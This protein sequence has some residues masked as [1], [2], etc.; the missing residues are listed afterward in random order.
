M[1]TRIILH[2]GNAHKRTDKNDKFFN[3]VISG[4]SSGETIRVL[5]I[6]FARPEHRW[7][8]SYDEDQYMFRR[9]ADDRGVEI[10]TLLATYDID[11]LTEKIAESDVI[12]INGGMKGH[13]KDTLLSFGLDRFRQMIEGKTLVGISA[14]ANI[15]TRYYYSMAIDGIREGTGFLNIKLLTHYSNDEPEKLNIL[16]AFGENLPVMTVAEEEYIVIN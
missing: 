1:T 14:G 3:E 6:Y 4:V 9:V 7:E 12:F 2:G 13:L 10:E 5:C 16:T 15:L 11:D 8:E